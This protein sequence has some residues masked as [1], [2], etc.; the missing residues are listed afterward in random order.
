MMLRGC[1]SEIQPCCT[2]PGF[3]ELSLKSG[4][5]PLRLHYLHSACLQHQHHVDKARAS[6][7]LA[8]A[9]PAW[10]LAALGSE[11][12]AAARGRRQHK[13]ALRKPRVLTFLGSNF[14]CFWPNLQVIKIFLFWLLYPGLTAN[15]A[16]SNHEPHATTSLLCCLE[17]SPTQLI[18]PSPGNSASHTTVLTHGRIA[19]KF[20]ARM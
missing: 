18:S 10:I 11:C 4:W 16:K 1:P 13:E 3:S 19:A 12:R 7:C 17:I 2:L 14:T 20:S 8:G 15:L 9:G 6:C 5:K